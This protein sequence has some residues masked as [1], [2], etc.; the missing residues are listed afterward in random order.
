MNSAQSGV[1]EV[2]FTLADGWVELVIW[3]SVGLQPLALN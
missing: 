1:R 2:I 3:R